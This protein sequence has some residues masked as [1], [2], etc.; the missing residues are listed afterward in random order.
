MSRT[1]DAKWFAKWQ[2]RIREPIK[3]TKRYYY[4]S[5]IIKIC[6][7]ILAPWG[8]H[9]LLKLRKF[10]NR[11]I[12][13]STDCLM[14][15]RTITNDGAPGAGKTFTGSNMAYFL[16]ARRWQELKSEYYT[17]RAM[18]AEW[19]ALGDTDRLYAFKS[20]EESYVF[21]AEREAEFIPC[22]VSSVPLREYGTERMSYELTPEVYAQIA[23]IPEYSVLFNDESG[24]LF[25]GDTSKSADSS[26][27]DFW[28]F[29][30]H[31]LD[32]MSVNTNQDGNQNGI[33][34]RRSTDYVNH[35]NGQ[36]WE[37]EPA[38]LLRRIVRR[39]ARFFK[40]MER[41]KLSE[42]RA[43]HI[44]QE[45]YFLKKYARTIGFRRVYHRLQTQTGEFAGDEGEYILPAI[46]GVEYDD[47]AYR[48]LYKCKDAAIKL[49]G[50]R[51][52]VPDGYD[53]AEYDSLI[54]GSAGQ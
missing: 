5:S 20:L 40:K 3:N 25:G 19:I 26:I 1:H 21:Y 50:W 9:R 51:T 7:V 30:R 44:G 46:G 4:R 42:K 43:E 45:L 17:Q 33:Y 49:E 37:L 29:I 53:R 24:L 12:N 10:L 16:A 52:L 38:R 32:A 39:E 34:M 23:K 18:L 14:Q 31:F 35:I 27:K 48:N 28:R 22:L 11:Y 6:T 13:L 2:A 41:G 8:L 47:R 54:S 15:G 36:T